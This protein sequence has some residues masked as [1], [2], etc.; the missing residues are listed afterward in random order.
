MK[1]LNIFFLTTLFASFLAV[2]GD[3]AAAQDMDSVGAY[4]KQVAVSEEMTSSETSGKLISQTVLVVGKSGNMHYAEDAQEVLSSLGAS[5]TLVDETALTGVLL[6]GY[7]V[8][9]IATGVAKTVYLAGKADIVKSYVNDGGG[10]IVEQPNE[11]GWVL[12]LPYDFRI[13]DYFYSGE[14]EHNV[15][16]PT[17]EIVEGLSD[18]ELL[19]CYDTVDTIGP[20]WEVLVE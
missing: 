3:A 20:E 5:A 14:C 12:V 13:V 11:V 17:H 18:D 1:N 15:L 4:G 10:L 9:W 7:D 8:V 16:Q 19:G 2:G 6:D